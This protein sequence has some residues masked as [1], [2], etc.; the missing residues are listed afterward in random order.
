MLYTRILWHIYSR[1]ELWSQQIQPLLGNRSENTPVVMQ[2][3]SNWE[4]VF[5]TQSMPIATYSN[6]E[7]LG[8]LFSMRP[9]LR[10]RK[11]PIQEKLFWLCCK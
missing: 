4:S 6:K 10:L 2:Q 11:E 5:S 7:L 1:Q 8:G 9:V 3:W